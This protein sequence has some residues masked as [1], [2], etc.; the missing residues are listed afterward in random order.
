M[1]LLLPTSKLTKPHFSINYLFEKWHIFWLFE[2]Q[3]HLYHCIEI[4]MGHTFDDEYLIICRKKKKRYQSLKC[5]ISP[6]IDACL[7][8]VRWDDKRENIYTEKD[9]KERQKINKKY[10]LLS[11]DLCLL[12]F[13][14]LDFRPTTSAMKGSYHGTFT[15][16]TLVLLLRALFQWTIMYTMMYYNVNK[17]TL[18]N[19]STLPWWNTQEPWWFLTIPEY[20]REYYIYTCR[21]IL[22]YLLD[23]SKDFHPA[24]EICRC[25]PFRSFPPLYKGK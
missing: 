18:E 21:R 9:N 19:T 15:E 4:S 24:L 3:T 6:D 12:M 20:V 16:S 17:I 13:T 14:S 1:Q 11:Y 23:Y 10:L 2:M 22:Q 7:F 25:G 8:L 5:W